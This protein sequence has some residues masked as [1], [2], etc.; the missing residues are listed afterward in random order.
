MLLGLD[1]FQ[2][3]TSDWTLIGDPPDTSTPETGVIVVE[4]PDAVT[5]LTILI[6]HDSFFQKELVGNLFS[7]YFRKS[8][9]L[10]ENQGFKW[11]SNPETIQAYF[12]RW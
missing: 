9:F 11:G 5:D 3:I 12:D 4:N 7:H 8:V 1:Q 2:R 10:H 6:A